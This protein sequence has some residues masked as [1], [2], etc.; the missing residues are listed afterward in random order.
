MAFDKPTRNALAKMVGGCRRLLTEDIRTQLQAV[1]GLQPDGSAL[2]LDTLGHLDESGRAIARELR[3]WQ[4]HLAATEIGT[5]SKRNA[6]A[7]DRMAGE[8][9][10][11][12]LNRLAALRMC[13]ER[14]HVVEC[15]HRGME[16]DGFQ[17]YERLLNGALGTRPATYRF[18]LERMFEELS[19]DLGVLFALDIPQSLVF[20]SELCL[21]Q[22]LRELNA[23]E[24]AHLWNQDETIG[25]I[26]QYFNSKEEREAMRE[27]SAAPRNSRELAVRNQFFTPRYVVEFLVDN[28]LGRIWYEMRE[29][30]TALSE[31]CRYLVRRPTEI[32]LDEGQTA[33]TSS[34]AEESVSQEELLGQPVYI[35]HRP[36]KDPRDLKILDPACG[37]GHFLLYAFDLL[38]TIYQESWADEQQVASEVT[39]NTLRGKYSELDSLKKALPEL[40]LRHNLHGID[41]DLRAC[42]IAALA[43]WLRAQQSYQR[44]A[45]K[46]SDRPRITRSNIVCA[47]PMPGEQ[48][49]LN[50]FL[51]DLQ[52]KAIAQLVQAV[53][54]K[55][56][57][58]GEAG[59][60]LKIEDEIAAAVS[61]AK[62]RWLA[63]PRPQQ[64]IL[65]AETAR[66]QQTE[67]GLDFSGITDEK[68]WERAEKDIYVALQGY[69]EQAEN[70]DGYQRRLFA[71]DA[72]RGFAF[73]DLC[74]KRYDIALMNPPFGDASLP[75]KPY[76]DETYGDTKGDIYKAFVECFQARL[77][78]A[79]YLGIISSRTG[80]FLGQSE[81]WRTRVVLRLFRPI[82]LADLG[83]GVLDAMVEVA[84][85]VLRNLSESEARDLTISLVPVL[86]RVTLDA[87]DRFSVPKWQASRSGL[88]RH[89][90]FA[91][92]EQ[93]QN[94]G[95]IRRCHGEVTRYTPLWGAVRSRTTPTAPTYP[96]LLCIRA[97]AEEQKDNVL[98]SAIGSIVLGDSLPSVF[99][100]DPAKFSQIP[101]TPFAY[102]AS[103]SVRKLFT[104]LPPFE[105]GERSVRVGLQTSDDNR[106]LR[107]WWEPN[108]LNFRS[109]WF[110]FAKG[111]STTSFLSEVVMVINWQSN[112]GELKSWA[113]TTSGSSHWS[114]NIR[115]PEFYFKPGLTWPL[116][117]SRFSPQILPE[118]C[119]FSIRGQVAFAPPQQLTWLL[120]L[121]ASR[122]FD[123]IY[124]TMLGRFGFP[125]FAVGVL[126]RVPIPVL[127]DT[128][129]A[130]LHSLADD[131]WRSKC[132]IQGASAVSRLFVV[133]PLMVEPGESL[134]ARASAWFDRIREIERHTDVIQDELDELSFCSY[135][136]S[137]S[138]REAMISSLVTADSGDAEAE[139]EDE[140][141]TGDASALTG[142]LL[143]YLVGI[144]FGRWDVRVATGPSPMHEPVDPFAPL[145]PCSPGQ[146]QNEH[147]LPLTQADAA[148]LR[149]A[150]T[151]NYPIDLPWA[152]I[153]VDDRGNADDIVNRVRDVLHIIWKQHADNVEQEACEILGIK[154]L[155][156][157]FRKP[158]VFFADH[159]KRYSKSRR[160]A[161]IYWPLSTASGSYTLWIYHHRLN[162]DT[163]FGA[164]NKYVKPKIEDTERKIRQL[165]SELTRTTGREAS[166]LRDA[167]EEAT[168]LLSELN[169]FQGELLRV[170]E[171]PYKPNLNDGVLITAAPLWKLFRLPKWRKDLQ[172]CWKELEAGEYDWAH[173]AYSIWPDRV[174]DVCKRD[175][176]IA[177]AHGLEE[178]CEV[179]VKPTKKKS[180]KRQKVEET[181]P[182][183]EE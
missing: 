48:E 181:V 70:G 171:L 14:G 182:G 36:K 81:D 147:G 111:G 116:R 60:L 69:S 92:L 28:T 93:L 117:A 53:F 183:D 113:E 16:S 68:F 180:S 176:S 73:I 33:P 172:E 23:P 155:R 40:I 58:A 30:N 99:P 67:L 132:H 57:I 123:A 105:S 91:E 21:E 74:R 7:F 2:A 143:D 95:F 108:P 109:I 104:C 59:S 164:V 110:P 179:A 165:E 154:D 166:K 15:V 46:S 115:S 77:I 148:L 178:L 78:P 88:K 84:S 18:F 152:G 72:A 24:L 27:A 141:S 90:A 135:G 127:S 149:A 55:M 173:L 157:Y 62:T 51:N 133:P 168:T 124:K 42:Q 61:E 136:L 11:T 49:L 13:E 19:V 20:P 80:F 4:Q 142:D 52:P 39:G 130:Q 47:E 139:A 45:F 103:T 76:L 63:G 26:Y 6:T 89:Q 3:E 129:K 50:E 145:P 131:V 12:V 126:Q 153:L 163:L 177:I 107:T 43:L 17:L 79:G 151:W 94:A 175:R 114:R 37:S 162:D 41:I 121:M 10:F 97:L 87:Q 106:F 64:G 137:D 118:G 161:P 66:P 38:E 120:G 167:L 65:F 34:V 170:A 119:I 128:N 82:V 96:L 146:L 169:D 102:W 122:A 83:M 150:G 156:E 159:L 44:L 35:T 85:Y 54:E 1:Y 31:A 158:T 160:Q 140:E 100:A 125:E 101:G 134:G 5:D 9:A 22:V 174:R 86:E 138:D 56:K 8:T 144:V 71:D 32:F 75:S 25:W 29:G 98:S 112:G